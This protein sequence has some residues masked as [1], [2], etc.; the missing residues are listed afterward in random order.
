METPEGRLATQQGLG[1]MAFSEDVRRLAGSSLDDAAATAQLR[2]CVS[3]DAELARRMVSPLAGSR[4]SYLDDREYR[5]LTAAIDGTEVRPIDPTVRE[6]LRRHISV[7]C[8]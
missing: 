5:L 8:R 7:G 3:E 4:T 6:H 1:Q 2:E